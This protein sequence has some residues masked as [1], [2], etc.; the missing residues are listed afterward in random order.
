MMILMLML[1]LNLLNEELAVT[2]IHS[3][4]LY[5]YASVGLVHTSIG[6]IA[7]A[8]VFEVMLRVMLILM[9]MLMLMLTLMLVLLL[10]LM[11]TLA[12]SC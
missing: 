12:S 5:H 2:S 6:R 10:V 11:L 4:I 1:V 7:L 3:H 8:N 9:L